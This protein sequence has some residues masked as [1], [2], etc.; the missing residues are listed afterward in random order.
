M[1]PVV[2]GIAQP[3]SEPP[4]KARNVT[5]TPKKRL[6]LSHNSIKLVTEPN[7]PQFFVST[8]QKPT[9]LKRAL[10]CSPQRASSKAP[11]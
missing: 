4:K 1:T 9:I 2:V 5:Q 11:C 6:S 10:P 7:Q 3:Q 8:L